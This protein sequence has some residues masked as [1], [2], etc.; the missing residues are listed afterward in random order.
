M[1]DLLLAAVLMQA[2]EPCNAAALPEPAPADCPR[3]QRVRPLDG[4]TGYIDRAAST[5]DGAAVEVSLRTVL[6]RPLDRG[7]RSL[8]ARVRLDCARRTTMI[9]H[10]IAFDE[11]GVRLFDAPVTSDT[12][13]SAPADS[14]YAD[15][16]NEYCPVRG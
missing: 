15:L 4:G 9:V 12:P 10:M 13:A 3:W 8:I 11:A 5:R 14:P 2:A 1:I 6:D 7:V 16:L